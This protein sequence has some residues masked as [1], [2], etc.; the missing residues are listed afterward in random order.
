MD[1][2][3]EDDHER[4]A[5]LQRWEASGAV[6]RVVATSPAGVTIALCRCDGGEEVDRGTEHAPPDPAVT[7][8][9][10]LA[11]EPTAC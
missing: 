9:T 10:A 1:A 2:D 6:W 3:V 7:H 11:A 8:L 5:A 4:V